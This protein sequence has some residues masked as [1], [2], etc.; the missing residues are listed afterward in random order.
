MDQLLNNPING[1]LSIIVEFINVMERSP[2]MR[3]CKRFK[4]VFEHSLKQHNPDILYILYLIWKNIE[5]N[6]KNCLIVRF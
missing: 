3:V 6:P 1:P 5:L 2:L 4:V